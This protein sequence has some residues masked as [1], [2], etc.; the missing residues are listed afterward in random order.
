MM[1]Y[2]ASSS[3][4]RR[5]VTGNSLWEHCRDCGQLGDHVRRRRLYYFRG[6]SI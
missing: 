5:A 4:A 1:P 3:I 2:V 6:T